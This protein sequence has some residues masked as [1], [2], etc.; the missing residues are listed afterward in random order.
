MNQKSTKRFATLIGASLLAISLAGCS[1]GSSQALGGKCDSIMSSIET[2]RSNVSPEYDDE[3][4]D[5]LMTVYV[6]DNYALNDVIGDLA[7]FSLN[8]EG[9][10]GS[11]ANYAIFQEWFSGI[12]GMNQYA[13]SS[14]EYVDFTSSE[15]GPVYLKDAYQQFESYSVE[16]EAICA[17][18]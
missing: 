2:V 3:Y 17:T 12:T 18:S 4:T 5:L 14:G 1:A 10:F 13:D 7:D 15:M 8:G 6:L 9:E 16:L 11:A